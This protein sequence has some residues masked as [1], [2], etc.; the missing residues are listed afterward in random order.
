[1]SGLNGHFNFN[2][3]NA[4]ELDP[5]KRYLGKKLS[6]KK[7]KLEIIQVHYTLHQQKV[8]RKEEEEVI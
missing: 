7:K 8:S 1:M 2:S 4:I 5:N 3:A 6:D